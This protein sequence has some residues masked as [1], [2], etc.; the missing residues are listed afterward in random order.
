M[1]LVADAISQ[2]REDALGLSAEVDSVG[3]MDRAFEGETAKRVAS[4]EPAPLVFD[5]AGAP[6]AVSSPIAEMLSLQL[7]NLA[8]SSGS[9]RR[10]A[11]ESIS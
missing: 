7:L 1:Q 11:L 5:L 10:C 6:T 3:Y 9:R 2:W 4:L 8:G